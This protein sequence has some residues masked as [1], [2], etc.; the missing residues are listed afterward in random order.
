MTKLFEANLCKCNNCDLILV[1]ENPQIGAKLYD[2]FE[3][4]N[5]QWV[6]SENNFV[7]KME[8]INEQ[9]GLGSLLGQ[10]FWGCP[11]CKTD[12]YLTDI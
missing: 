9:F 10:T 4:E 11:T 6:N 1:D 2:V 12:G 3:N 8:K 7:G 5:K